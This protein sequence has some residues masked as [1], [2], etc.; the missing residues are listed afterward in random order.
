MTTALAL[1]VHVGER[2][3]LPEDA[4]SP[5]RNAILLTSV[6]VVAERV[7]LVG[8]VE[9]ELALVEAL[10]S[11]GGEISSTMMA[12]RFSLPVCNRIALKHT[13]KESLSLNLKKV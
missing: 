9:V 10:E 7:V 12:G 11:L 13:S 3:D 5:G 1:T 6:I 8:R 4:I 2:A